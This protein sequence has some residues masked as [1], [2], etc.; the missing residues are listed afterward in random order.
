MKSPE[1]VKKEWE[2]FDRLV[3]AIEEC[4]ALR[5]H[6][7]KDDIKKSDVISFIEDRDKITECMMIATDSKGEYANELT[8]L[9]KYIPYE[10]KLN[11]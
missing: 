8:L 11:K 6:G 7:N 3:S 4:S 10:R 9:I 2:A 5:Y 1:E